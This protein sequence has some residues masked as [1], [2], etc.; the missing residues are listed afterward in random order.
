MSLPFTMDDVRAHC[1]PPSNGWLPP[2]D[3]IKMTDE[4]DRL[5]AELAEYRAESNHTWTVIRAERDAAQ[6]DIARVRARADEPVPADN[7]ER[8]VPA[9]VRGYTRCFADILRALDGAE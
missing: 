3:I 2:A 9:Y 1:S 7:R 5:R 8:G 4:I 6:A